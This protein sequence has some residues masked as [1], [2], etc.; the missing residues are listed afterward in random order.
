MGPLE[1]C[2]HTCRPVWSFSELVSPF[3][4]LDQC[5]C[6]IRRVVIVGELLLRYLFWDGYQSI[7]LITNWNKINLVRVLSDLSKRS[8]LMSVRCQTWLMDGYVNDFCRLPLP[9]ISAHLWNVHLV[10]FTC[11]LHLL[12]LCSPRF[13]VAAKSKCVSIQS[14]SIHHNDGLLIRS[15]RE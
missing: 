2:K 4:F 14:Q 9:F 13:P 3:L 5:Q 6:E 1:V 7:N 15:I 12:F 11:M 8:S 10:Y